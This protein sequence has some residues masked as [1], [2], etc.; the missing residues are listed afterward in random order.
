MHTHTHTHVHVPYSPI[1][2][3]GGKRHT[4]EVPSQSLLVFQ[5]ASKLEK[6]EPQWATVEAC[7]QQVRGPKV[8]NLM[9]SGGKGCSPLT[10]RWRGILELNFGGGWGYFQTQSTAERRVE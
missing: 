9:W 10:E 4:P 7:F 6:A 5:K 1:Q 2:E 8:R 3:R